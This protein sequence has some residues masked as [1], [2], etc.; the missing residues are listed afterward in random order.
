MQTVSSDNQA[1]CFFTEEKYNRIAWAVAPEHLTAEIINLPQDVLKVRRRM[2]PKLE[3]HVFLKFK[4]R[5]EDWIPIYEGDKLKLEIFRGA[6][7]T[8]RP[9]Y[10]ADP[11]KTFG[12]REGLPVM[13]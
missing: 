9:K 2:R 6:N 7:K 10:E 12:T 3:L 1:Q 8:E 13:D 4:D 11:Y 5:I